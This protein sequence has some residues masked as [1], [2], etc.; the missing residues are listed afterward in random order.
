M[1]V[2]KSSGHFFPFFKLDRFDD[3]WQTVCGIIWL[4]SWWKFHRWRKHRHILHKAF[5][6]VYYIGWYATLSFKG[7]YWF[8]Y[9]RKI[10]S[11]IQPECF[12]KNL[13]S[14]MTMSVSH[15]SNGSLWK[16]SWSWNCYLLALPFYPNFSNSNLNLERVYSIRLRTRL[17]EMK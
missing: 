15:I 14:I 6:V 13:I 16:I 4:S 3:F 17:K 10:F 11:Y 9:T 2:K 7:F 5:R 1:F 8:H 12:A